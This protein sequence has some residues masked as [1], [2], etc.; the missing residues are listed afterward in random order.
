MSLNIENINESVTHPCLLSLVQKEM[1]Y[2]VSFLLFSQSASFVSVSKKIN[3]SIQQ[4]WM[5]ACGVVTCQLSVVPLLRGCA[6]CAVSTGV[7]P[8]LIYNTKYTNWMADSPET[9]LCTH[10][11]ARDGQSGVRLC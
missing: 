3:T 7:F 10:T 1:K 11:P 4:A 5:Q 8:S 2:Y 9:Y 6:S